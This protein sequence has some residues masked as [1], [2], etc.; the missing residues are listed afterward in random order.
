[1]SVP[2]LSLTCERNDIVFTPAS[3]IS[4]NFQVDN[5]ATAFDVEVDDVRFM[6][7]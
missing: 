4:L 6:K 2:F 3:V 1:M 5:H 7:P